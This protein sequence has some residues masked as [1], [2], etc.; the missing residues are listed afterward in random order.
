MDLQDAYSESPLPKKISP[1]MPTPRAGTTPKPTA[2]SSAPPPA[3][4][5]EYSTFT[6]AASVLSMIFFIVFSYGAAKLSYDKY[7]SIGWAVLD[8][9]FSSFYYPYYAIVL[10]TPTV[11]GGRR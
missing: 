11:I 3:V 5:T 7:R 1:G 8:F 10:N 6:I 4:S 9:F 2:T